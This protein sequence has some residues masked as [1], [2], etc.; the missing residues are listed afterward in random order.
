[1]TDTELA[2]AGSKPRSQAGAEPLNSASYWLEGPPVRVPGQV[3]YGHSYLKTKAYAPLWPRKRPCLTLD[4]SCY[5]NPVPKNWPYRPRSIRTVLAV[6]YIPPGIYIA[7]YSHVGACL[8]L[9]QDGDQNQGS[10]WQRLQK[11]R[12]RYKASDRNQVYEGTASKTCKALR[13]RDGVHNQCNLTNRNSNP[14][15]QRN[16]G[17]RES[18]V[19]TLSRLVI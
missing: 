14:V 8:S 17:G 13:A 6:I 15:E 3:C 7:G 5:H 16:K 11:S 9:E 12:V 18:L 2:D 10:R 4:V 1:M 19:V